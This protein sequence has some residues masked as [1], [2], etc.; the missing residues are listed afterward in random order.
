MWNEKKPK[1]KSRTMDIRAIVLVVYECMSSKENP[2]R[3]RK[4]DCCVC[5]FL[6]F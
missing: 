6:F 1:A 4:E 2:C 3:S 5:I